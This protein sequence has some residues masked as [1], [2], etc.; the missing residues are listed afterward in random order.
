MEKK[1]ILIVE[2]DRIVALDIKNQMLSLG[3]SV[4]GIASSAEEALM[5][6]ENTKPD[7]IL[8][9]VKLR[10]RTDGIEAAEEIRDR[11]DIPVIFLTAFADAET[12]G[13]AKL[14]EPFGY[15]VKPFHERELHANIEMALY[16]SKLERELRDKEA[17]LRAVLASTTDG[18]VACDSSGSITFMNPIAETLTGWEQD[19]ALGKTLSQVIKMI[20]KR[21]GRAGQNL[22]VKLL[23]DTLQ[24]ELNHDLILVSRS[25]KE[26]YIDGSTAPI[27]DTKGNRTG[28]VMVIRDITAQKRSELSLRESEQ[29]YRTLVESAPDAL[30]VSDPDGR[31]IHISQQAIDLHGFDEARQLIGMNLLELIAP[32]DRERAKSHFERLLEDGHLSGIEYTF[33]RR[34]GT[35]F[36]GEI[37]GS[38]VK[39]TEENPKLVV[40]ST[41]DI[42]RRNQ[43]ENQL[44]ASKDYARNIIGCSLDMI[45]AVDNKRTITE[46]NRAAEESFG[47]TREE[48]V[49]KHVDLLYADPMEGIAVHKKTITNGH[50]L[51][52]I[53]N[54]R[55]NGENFPSLLAA[56]IL[57]DS[58]GDKIGVMGISRDITDQKLAE[59][60]LHK[61]REQLRSLSARLQTVREE[62]R[63]QISRELHDGLGQILTA[64]KM[65]LKSLGRKAGEEGEQHAGKIGG[66]VK[67]IDEGIETVRRISMELRPAS[68]DE[69]DISAAVK[70]EATEFQKRTGIQCDVT[71][72]P[73]NMKL[74]NDRST[75]VFRIVQEA[76][77]NVARHAD[78]SK[79]TVNLEARKGRLVVRVADNG[80]G[81]HPDQISSPKSLGL[82]GM[83]ERLYP[84]K[85]V[86]DIR[87]QKGRGTKVRASLPIG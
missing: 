27:G 71:V 80:S 73:K 81:I 75:A 42:T 19:R 10:G 4:L 86:L 40:T 36:I 45:I 58:H 13:R 82:T 52:E 57:L 21:P 14:T 41:R 49:G 63:V 15:I 2:D 84:W 39:N 74:D 1:S 44:R 31:I 77:T 32:E 67:L 83:R 68:L 26:R 18:V 48:V 53:L 24:S 72:S 79:V 16:N 34:D 28:S 65:E 7:L 66:T 35:H 51:Q 11:F 20:D 64:I 9:D 78:A 70:W 29:M 50:Y 3:Y 33:V 54:K 85:G 23:D 59:E 76:L 56:S 30:T 5:R 62:E 55:K 37:N 38:L 69:G 17:Y 12:V 60:R 25:G 46:F 6:I 8:M 43:A 87:G 22:A 61:S 47:Y